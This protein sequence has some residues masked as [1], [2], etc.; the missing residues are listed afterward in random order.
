MPG[1]KLNELYE[2]ENLIQRQSKYED[3]HSESR[4]R[5]K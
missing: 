2:T 5:N 3:I 4:K 1:R